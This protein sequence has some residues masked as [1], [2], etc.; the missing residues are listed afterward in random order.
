MNASSQIHATDISD[1]LADSATQIETTLDRLLPD[2]QG[3]ERP[4]L[5]AMRYA[6]LNG[7]KRLR[8]YLTTVT[9]RLFAVDETRA[10]RAAAA[11]EMLHCYSLVHDD[12]PAMDDDELRR[13]RPT[14]HIAFDEATAI[15]AGDALLTLAFDILA[16]P[17]THDDA[18]VRIGLVRGLTEAAGAHGM[19]A[20]QMIDLAV[21]HRAVDATTVERLQ[22]LKTGALITFSAEAG[23]ILGQAGPDE[24]EAIT[25]YGRDVGFAFQIV[26]DLL[27]EE[28]DQEAMGKAVGKD[29]AAGKATLVSVLGKDAARARAEELS[30]RAIASLE[31]FGEPA[32][33]LRN[34]ARFVVT[35]RT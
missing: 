33:A 10:L 14:C 17:A 26:D 23:A 2:G 29:A 27:D 20:G 19:V 3:H 31:P 22:A 16:D 24:R 18:G 7:G 6:C 13:G 30:A 28:G 11:V 5:E 15:L 4:L 25:A 9:A 8:P 35:R 1:V 32:E 34:V 21:E 12:L